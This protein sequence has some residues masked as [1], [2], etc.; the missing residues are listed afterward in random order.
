MEALD[1]S[2]FSSTPL[3][4]ME[5]GLFNPALDFAR[6]DGAGVNFTGKLILMLIYTRRG[7]TL[8]DTLTSGEEIT[9]AIARLTFSKIFTDLEQRV[10]YYKLLNDTDKIGI[11]KSTLTVK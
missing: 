7:G 6:S 9:I 10:Y 2:R 4:T 1:F 11:M 8:V 5:G 3:Q